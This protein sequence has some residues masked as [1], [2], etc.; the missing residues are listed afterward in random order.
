MVIVCLVVA[1]KLREGRQR[2]LLLF[3]FLSETDSIEDANANATI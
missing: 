1:V 3:H 2:G